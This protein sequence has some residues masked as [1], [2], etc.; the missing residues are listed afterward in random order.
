MLDLLIN[1]SFEYFRKQSR[2]KVLKKA[3][4]IGDILYKINYRKDVVE[5]NLT[6]AFPEK[7]ESW[8][9][10]IRRK[11]LQNIGRVLAEFPKQ[12]DY[13]K[14]GYI[15]DIV[16]IESGENLLDDIKKIGGIIVSGHLSNWE[17]GGAGLSYYLNGLTSLAYRQ[18]NEKINKIITKIR[19]DSGIKIIYHDQPLK[20]FINALKNKEVISF[21]ID[22]NALKHRGYFVDFFGLKAST[23]NFPAKLVAKYQVPILFSYIYFNEKDQKYYI[24]TQTVDYKI[25]T[26]EEETAFNITQ[27]YTKKVEEAVKKHPDQYF[28]VHKRWKTRE[29]ES[30]EKIY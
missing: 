4:L 23:V 18:K 11:S 27:S 2:E 6:I 7:D 25:G 14:S 20:H 5:K 1:L 15:K 29:D 9:D 21:L 28:W 24:N 16:S 12:P 13:V 10:Y 19:E 30:K 22:Q 8:K 26:S 3:N 17:M